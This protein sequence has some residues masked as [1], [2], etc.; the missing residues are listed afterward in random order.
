MITD[1]KDRVQAPDMLAAA[2]EYAAMGWGVIP[3]WWPVSG[4]CAC[5]RLEC[6]ATGKH[7]LARAVPHG[8]SD[9]TTD[10][11][12]IRRWWTSWPK[13]NI[14][15]AT[16]P[17]SKIWMLGPDGAKGIEAQSDL[18]REHYSL[19][20]TVRAKSGN[21]DPGRHFIFSWPGSGTIPNLRNHRGLPI[22]VRGAG[23]YFIAAPSLHKSGS[24]YAWEIAPGGATPVADAPE[25]LLHWVR[26]GEGKGVAAPA[27]GRSRNGDSAVLARAEKYL[28]KCDPAISGQGGHDQTFAV[29]RAIVY[30]FDLGADAGYD[31]LARLYN[32]RCDPP[33]N[34]K[35]LQHKCRDADSRPCDKTRGW[36]LAEGRHPAAAA[37]AR[38]STAAPPSA[39][40]DPEAAGDRPYHP[41]PVEALP[42]PVRGF[43]DAGARAIGCDPSYLALPLLTAMGAAIGNTRR[44]ELKRG[45][46]VP[47][48]LWGAI[49]GESGTCKTPAFRLVMRPVRDRQ[50]KALRR[51]AQEM[52]EH[53]AELAR[54][55][56]D[57][58]TWKKDKGAGGDAPEK[59]EPPPCER[60]LVADTTIEA[61]APILHENPR[62]VLL[63]RD[64]LAGWIGSFDRYASKGKV[65][66][67]SPNWLSMFNAESITVDRKS[68]TPR[69]IHVPDA[70]VSICGGIQPG[71]LA[72]ALGTE[73]YENG[74]AARLLLT[75]PPRA[76]KRWTE[77]DIDPALEED[78]TG[79]YDRLFSLLAT[80]NDD[81][82]DEPRPLIIKL[83]PEAKQAWVTY[84]DAHALEQADLTGDL[85]AAW[86]KLE[87]YAARLALVIHYLRWAAWQVE[88]EFRLDLD[89]MTAGIAL[90]NWFKREAERV[91][92]MLGET[93]DARDYRRLVDWIESKGGSV[94]CREVQ[95]GCRW[96]RDS[97]QAEAALEALVKARRGTWVLSPLARPGQPTRHFHLSTVST[98]TI[99]AKTQENS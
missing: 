3:C 46:Y 60:F 53:A 10:L 24:R 30:G 17:A 87:E 80:V 72:R 9:A 74:L 98:V 31:L 19:P 47:P 13:A 63:A 67:D 68:G 70:A 84:Y 99:P 93:D 97:G 56:I 37:P 61:L 2:L 11:D 34:E 20:L 88:D 23:G 35:E 25:W 86:S 16:G 52:K 55:E 57:M 32:P 5:G 42:D 65:G 82:D 8:S 26:A 43:V 6:T 94:T 21:A 27:R 69:T 73:H 78:L 96:L 58:S 18:E 64:E 38:G 12:L 89:S 39:T 79:I 83:S 59:P 85:A 41:F 95:R 66:A 7:P 71:I 62:G 54:W 49:V 28:A 75:C 4:G 45:W 1:I 15:I 36:L 92:A 90:A 40:P 29:A 91:Y 50:A 77:A 14:G 33:W 48:I 22:D 44:L 51:H 76:P 81:D